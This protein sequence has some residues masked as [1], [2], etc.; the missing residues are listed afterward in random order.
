MC[1]RWV[2]ACAVAILMS[3]ACPAGPDRTLTIESAFARAID[4]HPELARFANLR[5]AAEAAVDAESLRPP[6]RVDLEIENAPRSG[7]DSA[8]DSTEATLSLASVV[9]RGGKRAAR[10]ALASAAY[11]S[12]ALQEEQRRADVLAE[13]ARRY[14]DFVGA[15][16]LADIASTESEQRRKVVDAASRRVRAGATPDSVRLAADAA[17]TRATLLRDRLRAETTAAARRLAILWN[18]RTPDFERGVGDPRAIPATPTLDELHALLE[19]SPE[20]RRFSDETR[21]REARVQLARSARAT[22]I[23]WR[24]GVRRLEEDGSWAAVIGVS[25]PLGVSRRAE[26]G[27]RA[28]RAELAALSLEREAEALTLEATLVDAHHRLTAAAAEVAATRDVLLPKLEQAERAAERAY[29]A[30]ALT[31]TEWSQ[32]QSDAMSAR[33]DQVLAALEAHRALIEIQRLTGSAFV[34]PAAPT[35]TQP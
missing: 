3:V 27:V 11:D 28:A 7:R 4:E 14:L 18:S 10:R 1:L 24:A 9:E 30:G 31:Y 33:R 5:D 22:D 29:R 8:F 2:T 26:P 34:S 16:T 17:W 21:L 35:G 15:Q 6:M 13:V 25:V 23:D 32:M 19:R 12:L 20:L